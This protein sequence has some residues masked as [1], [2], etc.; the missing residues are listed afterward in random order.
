MNAAV[1]FYEVRRRKQ[2]IKTQL[3]QR[4]RTKKTRIDSKVDLIRTIAKLEIDRRPSAPIRALP[5]DRKQT[6]R[7]SQPPDNIFGSSQKVKL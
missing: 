5:P 7:D 4:Q 3:A 6:R 2:S 1:R